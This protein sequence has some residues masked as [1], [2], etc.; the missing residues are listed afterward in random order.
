M[1]SFLCKS[2]IKVGLRI[3]VGWLLHVLYNHD[4]FGL[5]LP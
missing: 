3:S 5:S 2:D 1:N 4:Q